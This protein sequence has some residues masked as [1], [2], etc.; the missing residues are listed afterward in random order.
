MGKRYCR[1]AMLDVAALGR[2]CW[3][4]IGW[5]YCGG[6]IGCDGAGR[7][8]RGATPGRYL[9]WALWWRYWGAV[10]ELHRG[11]G[12]GCDGAGRPSLGDDAGEAALEEVFKTGIVGAALDKAV[13]WGGAGCCGIG[14]GSGSEGGTGEG[15]IGGRPS[16]PLSPCLSPNVHWILFRCNPLPKNIQMT[17]NGIA[18]KQ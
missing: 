6:G 18:R 13:P 14:A 4:C 3:N 17:P 10:L 7:P 15:G 8:Y 2:R 16:R 12:I 1:R 5:R 9:R 11:G